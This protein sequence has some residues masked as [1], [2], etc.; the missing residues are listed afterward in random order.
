MGHRARR[1]W[2]AAVAAGGVGFN[3]PADIWPCTT[4]HD[5]NQDA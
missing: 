2:V 5:L 1:R 4:T 3:G